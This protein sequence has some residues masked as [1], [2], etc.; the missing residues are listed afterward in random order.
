KKR[1][2]WFLLLTLILALNVAMAGAAEPGDVCGEKVIFPLTAG[3]TIDVGRITVANTE[4]DLI[5]NYQTTGDWY[6]QE[7]H[8][9]VLDYEPTERLT[10]GQAPHKVEGINTQNWTLVIPLGEIEC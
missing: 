9:Y 8:L 10:P 5:I 3:Q 1:T 2:I 6:L 4:T 7:L